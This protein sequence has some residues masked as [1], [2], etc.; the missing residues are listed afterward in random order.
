MDFIGG[1]VCGGHLR[2]AVSVIGLAVWQLPRA[3]IGIG[4]GFV[5]L[6]VRDQVSVNWR[7]IG[8]ER[9]DGFID[10]RVALFFGDG[11][12]CEERIHFVAQVF[13]ER[14]IGFAVVKGE[15]CD[16]ILAALDHE[17]IN[18]ERWTNAL[19]RIGFRI[20]EVLAEI[21]IDAIEA[22]DVSLSV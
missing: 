9:G 21:F 19:L 3:I 20:G 4:V 16:D 18:K 7:N 2:E 14:A 17:V 1:H 13:H 6:H 8:F 22:G 11:A 15:T 5:G 12:V 10:E